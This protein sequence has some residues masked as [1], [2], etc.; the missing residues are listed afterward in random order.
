MIVA[1]TSLQ[2]IQTHLCASLHSMAQAA[3]TG[4]DQKL[5]KV[6]NITKS[7]IHVTPFLILHQVHRGCNMEKKLTDLLTFVSLVNILIDMPMFQTSSP[8]SSTPNTMFTTIC[9]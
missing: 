9:C 6:E 3:A 7:Q 8:I 5:K 4:W 1:H 2:F